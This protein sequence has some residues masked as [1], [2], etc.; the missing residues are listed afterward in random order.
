MQTPVRNEINF[1]QRYYYTAPST[2]EKYMS[3]TL[4]FAAQ[5][6]DNQP[7]K[8]HHMHLLDTKRARWLLSNVHSHIANQSPVIFREDAVPCMSFTQ[9]VSA[10]S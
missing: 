2:N 5:N 9:Y 3:F 10:L 8:I 4:R 7:S 1:T 6:G